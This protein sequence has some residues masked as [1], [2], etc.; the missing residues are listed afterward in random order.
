M[1]TVFRAEHEETRDEYWRHVLHETLGLLEPRGL[2][3]RMVAGEVGVVRVGEITGSG[4]GGALRATSHVRS[5]DPDVYKL[6]LLVQGHGVIEQGGREARL[7]PGDFTLIDFSRP[8]TWSVFS[9]RLVA[10][11]FPRSLLPLRPADVAKLTGVRIAGDRGAGALVSS[12]ASQLPKHLDEWG[13]A[14]GVRLGTAVI[15][16][17]TAA[18]AARLERD[19]DVEADSRQRALLLRVHA[20]IEQ[21]LDDPALAPPMI[22]DAHFI[23]LRYLHKL[24]EAEQTSVAE[25]IR[26]RRLERCRRDLLD[27][28]LRSTPVATIAARWGLHNPAHF[29][30]LFRARYGLPPAEFRRLAA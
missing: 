5:S 10:L 19:R 21:R 20:F 26:R 11:S 13:A 23:S 22:G 25:W 16:M 30:R 2:P 14:D 18:L 17:L 3:D 24:F 12:L 29:S 9:S 27:P 15:D 7:G 4:Q 28:A 6:D 1:S 8:A